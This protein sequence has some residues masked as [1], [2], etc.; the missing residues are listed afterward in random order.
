MLW[1]AIFEPST[2][3]R[4]HEAAVARLRWHLDMLFPSRTQKQ[5]QVM[6]YWSQVQKTFLDLSGQGLKVL[7]CLGE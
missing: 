2:L 3:H 4:V 5:A 6:H 1:L 7:L